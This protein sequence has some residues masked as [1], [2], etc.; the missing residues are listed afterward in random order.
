MKTIRKTIYKKSL[1]GLTVQIQCVF[2][3]KHGL[4][5][6]TI[7]PDQGFCDRNPF[8]VIFRVLKMQKRFRAVQKSLSRSTKRLT[9]AVN[10]CGKR[11]NNCGGSFIC[12]A[13]TLK[14]ENYN[15]TN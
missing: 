15:E 2:D 1:R 5:F 11:T 12:L 13:T 7:L 9:K 4:R 8:K 14:K 6:S 10:V 3:F